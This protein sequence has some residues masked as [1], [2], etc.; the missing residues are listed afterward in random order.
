MTSAVLLLAALLFNGSTEPADLLLLPVSPSAVVEGANGSIWVS[1]LTVLNSGSYT[2]KLAPLALT[3]PPFECLAFV[4]VGPGEVAEVPI[5]ES[6]DNP[7]PTRFIYAIP[8]AKNL[9][10]NFRVFSNEANALGGVIPVLRVQT[11]SS[12]TLHLLAL[13]VC[14]GVR[15]SVRVYDLGPPP[16]TAVAAS[17]RFYDTSFGRNVFLSEQSLPITFRGSPFVPGYGE[18]HNLQQFV[19]A[20][21]NQFRIEIVPSSGRPLWAFVCTVD[22]ANS[23]VLV[24]L[25]DN[26]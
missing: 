10:F 1:E 14:C 22:A 15:S 23:A 4:E 8:D 6:S 7:A 11:P 26:P 19:P 5:N 2:V 25:P 12:S 16:S 3:C 9:H 20:A 13:P 18:I 21:T 24:T 17:V